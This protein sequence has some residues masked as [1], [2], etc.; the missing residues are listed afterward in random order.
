MFRNVRHLTLIA[1]AALFATP[2]LAQDV[3]TPA[4][5]PTVAVPVAAAPAAAKPEIKVTATKPDP[6][7]P[8]AVVCKV[9]TNTGS[10]IASTKRCQ[11]RRQWAEQAREVQKMIMD[12]P[13]PSAGSN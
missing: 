5:P 1:S 13:S 9:E 11:T 6:T 3:V 8:D 7:D 2:A 4:P 10:R 12:K